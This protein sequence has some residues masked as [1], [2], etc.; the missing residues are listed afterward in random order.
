MAISLVIL[1][2]VLLIQ[3][4]CVWTILSNILVETCWG[5]GWHSVCIPQRNEQIKLSIKHHNFCGNLKEMKNQ[6][7]SVLTRKI[8][9][10]RE[11]R[12]CLLEWHWTHTKNCLG[13]KGQSIRN[14]CTERRVNCT[15]FPSLSDPSSLLY[16]PNKKLL[17]WWFVCE[18]AGLRHTS[19]STEQFHRD[20][21]C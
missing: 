17:L 14:L 6:Y 10:Q 19:W 16:V 2:S 11:H 8:I 4:V 21:N 9:M 12:V 15:P 7:A 18:F 5:S 3:T 20:S 13:E 1:I